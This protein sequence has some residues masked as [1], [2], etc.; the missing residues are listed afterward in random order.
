LC[1]AKITIINDYTKK[2]DGNMIH[3]ISFFATFAP[4]FNN[5]YKKRR[6]L[7]K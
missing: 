7:W 5:K 4:E 3:P 6:L 1:S 2:I